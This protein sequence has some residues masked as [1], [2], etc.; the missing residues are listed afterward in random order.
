MVFRVAPVF[1]VVQRRIVARP[2]E[3]DDHPLVSGGAKSRLKQVVAFHDVL[4][5]VVVAVDEH[6]DVAGRDR[7]APVRRG[8]PL[9]SPVGRPLQNRVPK[10]R[11]ANPVPFG[12]KPWPTSPP[13][14]RLG[15]AARSRMARTNARMFVLDQPVPSATTKWP[16]FPVQI[17][18]M[19][20]NQSPRCRFFRE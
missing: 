5:P 6:E 7:F 1:Q 16:W 8:L 13:G 11:A 2:I 14:P 9:H 4:D 17:L 3:A 20:H 18:G 19:M 15:V 12:I 10:G